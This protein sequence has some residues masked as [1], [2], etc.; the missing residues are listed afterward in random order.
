MRIALFVLMMVIGALS[1]GTAFAQSETDRLR[2]ALRSATAQTR[3]LEDQR[4][5]LQAKVADA[6]REK[7][8][9]KKEVDD[10]KAQLKKADKEH[11]DAVDE[12]N[13]RLAE[14]DD[15]LEK[16]KSAYEEAATV[17]RT[18]DAERA[19]FEGEAT[20]YKASTKSCVAKNAQ[21]VKAGKEMV[22]RYKDL[23]IGEIVVSREP[24]IQQRRVEI[25]NQ[26]QESTDK[27]LDQK[28]NP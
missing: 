5:A 16:W 14:R 20:A 15:T 12:F 24:M 1:S 17:A 4:T 6:D 27:F 2:E 28:V 8:A 19:K 11:R 21:L 3:A 9:A 22:Q 10:L 26:L 18:K 23:T 7:A 13:Q 25:Q